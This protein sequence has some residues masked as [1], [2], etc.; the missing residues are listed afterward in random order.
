MKLKKFKERDNKKI[1]VVVFTLICLFLVSGAILYRTFAIFEV[2]INQ[3]VINGT[4]QTGDILFAFYYEDDEV[5][6]DSAEI[7]Y[8]NVVI[9]LKGAEDLTETLKKENEIYKN[10]IKYIP[11]DLN[12]ELI[13]YNNNNI[14]S[15][16]F[17]EYKNY[18]YEN[19]VSLVL[20]DFNYSCFDDITFYKTKSYV[21]DTE[22][23]K[24]IN[25]NDLLNKYNLNMDNVK[26]KMR[27]Y[28]NSKQSTDEGV[29]VIKIDETID[30]L[31]NYAFYINNYG[32]LCIT[33]LVKTT[34]VD[35]NEDMEVL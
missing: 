35:Y 26:E 11:D 5:I 16:V 9:N 30:T 29:E 12:K 17:R 32:H 14:Y 21:F 15:L 7:N 10:N 6:S 34:Q 3:N 20:N 8:R 22:S 28:L 27:G 25:E 18:E 2:R 23:G 33:Y 1:G 24:V 13:K 31:D 19:L 4:V